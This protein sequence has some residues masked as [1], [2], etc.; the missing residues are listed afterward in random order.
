MTLIEKLENIANTSTVKSLKKYPDV[1]KAKDFDELWKNVIEPNLPDKNAVIGWHNLLMQYVQQDN[2]VF[3][4]R[5]CASGDHSRRGCL[6][7]VI[8]NGKTTFGTFCIDNGIP[9]YIYAMAKDKFV[10]E[11]TEFNEMM[12]HNCSFPFGWNVTSEEKEI[13][14]YP[15]GKNPGIS[16]KGYKLAHIFPAGKEYSDDAGY[17]T[18]TKFWK[19]EFPKKDVSDWK[20]NK[21]AS[22]KYYRPIKI[23][24]EG[25]VEK[26]RNFAVAHFLRSVH[27]LNFFL[28]PKK[29]NTRDEES[30]ILKTNI[31]YKDHNGK[32]QNEIGEYFKLIEYVAAK[33]KDIY[34]DTAVYQEFLDMIFP[35]GNCLDPRGANVEINAEYAIG[36][37]QRKKGGVSTITKTKSSSKT[38]PF[39]KTVRDYSH[40]NFLE[41]PT[42]N[43]YGKGRLVLAVV[44]Q[45]VKDGRATSYVDL[46]KVFP[47]E[48]QGSSGVVR[49]FDDV[50]DKDKGIGGKPRYYVNDNDIIRFENGDKVIVSNQWGGVDKMDKFIDYVVTNLKYTIAKI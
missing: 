22:G 49:L 25:K 39:K 18:I 6:N 32:E 3:T 31:Y 40:Y 19:A 44:S 26:V 7:Q 16:D 17:K 42:G 8:V 37:W 27:P 36:I 50:S 14:A 24:D 41:N 34:K 21:L 29:S 33:I 5:A 15:K 4:L 48:L 10:P 45:Y 43:P 23:N 28:V 47:D 20:Q 12:I 1:E 46:K 30:G 9:T 35:I 13:A 2:A 38:Y 11:L